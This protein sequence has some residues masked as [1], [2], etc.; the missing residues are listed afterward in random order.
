MKTRNILLAIATAFGASAASAALVDLTQLGYVTYGDAN[1][2]SLAVGNYYTCGSEYGPGCP[3][4]VKGTPGAEEQD[5][6]LYIVQG[7]G[8][9]MNNGNVNIDDAFRAA[10]NQLYFTMTADNEP[11]SNGTNSSFT[12]DQNN[13]WDATLGA[14]NSTF[15]FT[16]HY[17]TFFFVNNEPNSQ[18]GLTQNLAVW[19]RITLTDLSGNSV[20]KT[21]DL[22]NDTRTSAQR[23]INDPAYLPPP[24]YGAPPV[25]GGAPLGDVTAYTSEGLEPAITDFVM[26]GG[27]VC[28]DKVSKAIVNCST[29][30]PGSFDT[31]NHNLGAN[32]S[33]YAVTVPEL[34]SYITSLILNGANL[35]DYV[36]RVDLRYGCVTPPFSIEGTGGNA[37]CVPYGTAASQDNNFEQVFIS[38]RLITET[39]VPE[40]ATL[41]LLGSSLLGLAALRRRNTA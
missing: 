9:H 37:N 32:Q 25:G 30:T 27:A 16:K 19:A 21:F 20:Y 36:M 1:S 34:D 11:G 23:D 29:A 14:L 7:A 6:R 3:Y 35:N 8:G 22:T 10:N 18:D 17:M 2:Y 24:G 33:P 26:S 5:P 15:D 13:T 12:G 40:P 28:I 31:I 4:N 41:A 39:R 38:T